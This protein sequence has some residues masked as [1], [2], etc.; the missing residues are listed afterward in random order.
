MAITEELALDTTSEDFSGT[1]TCYWSFD[2]FIAI[3][4]FKTSDK[5][6]LS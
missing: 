3:S 6:G 5:A 4:P 2:S 1:A